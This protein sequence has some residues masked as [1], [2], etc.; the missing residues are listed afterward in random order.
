MASA[1]EKNLL[2]C[3][4]Y[5]SLIGPYLYSLLP[6]STTK[7]ERFIADT[8]HFIFLSLH[9]PK[10]HELRSVYCHCPS[11]E[12][13]RIMSR[14]HRWSQLLHLSFWRHFNACPHLCVLPSIRVYTST[15]SRIV[16]QSSVTLCFGISLKFATRSNFD[17]N[18]KKKKKT[19]TLLEHFHA[20]LYSFLE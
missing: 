5:L 7:W 4:W 10:T 2:C 11:I 14:G 19:S 18:L 9:I 20:F 17:W 12:C 1:Q 8:L 15:K 16:E 3:D 13:T 6:E